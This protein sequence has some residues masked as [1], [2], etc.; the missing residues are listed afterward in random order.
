MNSWLT[1]EF[2]VGHIFI[3]MVDSGPQ[4]MALPI[5]GKAIPIQASRVPGG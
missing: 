5:K 1:E 4:V 2:S 3:F